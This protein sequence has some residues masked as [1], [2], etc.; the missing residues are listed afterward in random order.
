MAP[1]KQE[2]AVG[3]AVTFGRFDGNPMRWTVLE[4]RDDQALI[5]AEKAVAHMPY[6]DRPGPVAWHESGIWHWL[7]T[8]FYRN[9]F[10]DEERDAVSDVQFAEFSDPE[11]MMDTEAFDHVFLLSAQEASDCFRSDSDRTLTHSPSLSGWILTRSDGL[12]ATCRWWLRGNSTRSGG[13]D[14]IPA[15][16]LDG[17]PGVLLPSHGTLAAVRP[18]MRVA[19]AALRPVSSDDR[20]EPLLGLLKTGP[21]GTVTD[22]YDGRPRERKVL[23]AFVDYELEHEY[24]MINRDAEDA[25]GDGPTFAW[26][27]VDPYPGFRAVKKLRLLADRLSEKPY[28]RVAAD[29]WREFSRH[30]VSESMK[31][32]AWVTEDG[33][34]CPELREGD[35]I[36]LGRS[37]ENEEEPIRWKILVRRGDRAMVICRTSVG[38]GPWQGSDDTVCTWTNSHLRAWLT[39]E[40]FERAFTFD[41]QCVT[42]PYQTW[43]GDRLGRARPGD[44]P[45]FDNCFLLS[46]AELSVFFPDD[47]SRR[48]LPPGETE[49]VRWWTRS[50]TARAGRMVCVEP[51]GRLNLEGCPAASCACAVRPSLLIRLDTLEESR[52]SGLID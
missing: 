27:V 22:F 32:L 15:C 48:L 19:C 24:L 4:I 25:F 28:D 45:V 30:A 49:G 26:T 11:K 17:T 37:P 50:P 9:S 18:A 13:K 16:D 51:D 52:R 23:A 34:A 43:F 33:N 14:W 38:W 40:F 20:A 42:E 29:L 1:R 10:S 35:E 2:L 41:E 31:Q 7:N 5:L 12:R 36:T 46:D 44:S 3:A 39:D 6:H 47:A 8:D 21:L